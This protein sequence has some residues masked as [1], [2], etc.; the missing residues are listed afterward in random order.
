MAK[1]QVVKNL[2]KAYKSY[3]QWDQY[4][5]KYIKE[6]R[7]KK[8]LDELI[9]FSVITIGSQKIVP[10]EKYTLLM[11]FIIT[12]N[13][14]KVTELL[15]GDNPASVLAVNEAGKN[16]LFIAVEYK[17]I[18]LIQKL[19]SINNHSQFM[20]TALI[21]RVTPLC[22]AVEKNLPIE[23]INEL[24]K[25]FPEKQL[26][27][28]NSDGMIPLG[29]GCLKGSLNV[30]KI[31]LLHIP[32]EQLNHKTKKGLS[33][34]H[35][36]L[37]S[38]NY[39]LIEWIL[40]NYPQCLNSTS[41][42]NATPLFAVC[43]SQINDIRLVRLLLKNGAEAQILINVNGK[44]PLSVAAE[45]NN[46]EIVEELLNFELEKQLE[47]V[48]SDGLTPLARACFFGALKA[49]N[50]IITR[51]TDVA[52]FL[53]TE[54]IEGLIPLQIAIIQSKNNAI[55]DVL[56]KI[57]PDEQLSKQEQKNGYT[58]LFSCVVKKDIEKIKILVKYLNPG[59]YLIPDSEGTTPFYYAAQEGYTEICDLLLNHG[60]SEQLMGSLRNSFPIHIAANRNHSKV[61]ELII[62]KDKQNQL[63]LIDKDIDQRNPL[64]IAAFN[65]AT[66]VAI[67]LVM[68]GANKCDSDKSGYLPIHFA[69]QQG[70]IDICRFLLS[71]DL[72]EQLFVHKKFD[73]MTPLHLAIMQDH[74]A[75]VELIC[76]KEVGLVVE[77][78]K[79]G[80][81]RG[82]TSLHTA[83]YYG[84]EYIEMLIKN[85]ANI[86]I[87]D[88]EG[89]TPLHVVCFKG[90]IS[91]F[92]KLISFNPSLEIL[93][94][95]GSNPLHIACERGHLLLIQKLLK[96][97]PQ[98]L[99]TK[100]KYYRT[101][102][103]CAVVFGHLE[104]A[105]FFMLQ[106]V[107]INIEII[108]NEEIITPLRIAIE[109]YDVSMIKLLLQNKVDIKQKINVSSDYTLYNMLCDEFEFVPQLLSEFL[110][111][112]N[113]V[114]QSQTQSNISE[115]PEP[116]L[117]P[118]KVEKPL[119]G[120]T[121]LK[122][123]GYTPEDILALEEERS[124]QHQKL[125]SNSHTIDKQ[126]SNSHKETYCWCSNLF[127]SSHNQIFSIASPSTDNSFCYLDIDL[128]KT[129]GCDEAQC[130]DIRYKFGSK[131][132]KKLDD[133]KSIITGK[134]EINGQIKTVKYTHELKL[135][136]VDRVLLF[137]FPSDDG[138]ACL[139]I[140]ARFLP[141]GLHVKADIRDVKLSEKTGKCPKIQLPNQLPDIHDKKSQNQAN[142]L[143]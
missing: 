82:F 23:I 16:G 108:E 113:L 83:C 43:L 31:L 138:K 120:R 118:T 22:Y 127:N 101:P 137:E 84:Y 59:I 139:Y 44:I 102:F 8:K 50:I 46:H 69:A 51:K 94:N 132:I 99:E 80:D 13:L 89:W 49:V 103:F 15:K 1:E 65:N 86:N 34:F 143:K 81:H 62:K 33:I 68:N 91:I 98:L 57:V 110:A 130:K 58:S 85:G 53:L 79:I 18:E 56:L 77:L 35:Y 48:D 64:H 142:S 6:L 119:T 10:T 97:N 95:V 60:P 38:Q 76:Q 3:G 52:K 54:D 14:E 25:Y 109:L 128:L 129:Q 24:L 135:N 40:Q 134:V 112:I 90:Y 5:N 26:L 28:R 93:N 11:Y 136:K 96:L 74:V 42:D 37:N 92:E 78:L 122:S 32:L 45:L 29:W 36:A 88:G 66:L 21:T 27:L 61:V 140:G 104:A 7:K 19:A 70:N 141:F 39:E 73:E 87:Q 115:E 133:D 30:V 123:I 125:K 20:I 2:E 116:I 124:E 75:V 111:F 4:L 47:Y 41:I 63:S 114:S 107:N 121:Y 55:I 117:Q 106:N 126:W 131:H 67:V 72:R 9:S 71:K 12:N 17:R 100:D 105:K